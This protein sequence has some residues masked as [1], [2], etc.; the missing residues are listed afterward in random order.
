M[1]RFRTAW[2]RKQRT[3][4]DLIKY[5]IGHS[6]KE[7][8]TDKYSKLS[9]DLLYRLEEAEKVGAGIAIPATVRPTIPRIRKQE[10]EPMA[11]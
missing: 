1:R 9:E 2:L 6:K 7:S 5:W 11:A 3:P 10:T 8:R 4:E